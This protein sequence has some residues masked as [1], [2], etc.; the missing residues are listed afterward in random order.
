MPTTSSFIV[1]PITIIVAFLLTLLPM[2]EWALWMRPAWVLMVLIYWSM[3]LPYRVN[4]GIAWITGIFLDVMNGTL[5]GEHALALT[6]VIYLVVRMS[7][8][9]RMFPLL[10]QGLCVL[11]LTLVYQ[12]TLF[13]IQG[14]IGELP[15][16]WAYW[17]TSVTS[18][19]LWPWISIIMND[20]R[21]RFRVI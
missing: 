19:L 1:I 10:Q 18:M 7:S 3:A 5:F 17:L 9:L 4:V 21:R 2:P 15:K 13:C 11:L 8:R 6:L 16:S 14:F 20:S 12:F